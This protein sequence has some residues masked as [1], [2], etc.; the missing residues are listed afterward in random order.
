MPRASER[1]ARSASHWLSPRLHWL[2]G[3]LLLGGIVLR[4]LVSIAYAPALLYIDSFRYL[5][6]LRDL[7]PTQLN[8]V[9]YQLFLLKPALFVTKSL[10]SVVIIQHLLGLALAVAIYVVLLRRGARAWVAALATAPVLLDAYQVQIEHNIMSD[11]LF[12]VLLIAAVLLLIWQGAPRVPAAVFAGLLLAAAVITRSVAIPLIVPAAVYVLLVARRRGEPE[13]R[14]FAQRLGVTAALVGAFAL[15]VFSYATYYH[16]YSGSWGVA[17]SSSKVL[18][19]RT[20]TVADC[21][22]LDLNPA[23]EPLC[24]K[25]PLGERYGV[26]V[27]THGLKGWDPRALELADEYGGLDATTRSF[28]N[29]V[30]AAQPLDVAGAILLDFLKNFSLTKETAPNDVPVERWHFQTEYPRW[31]LDAEAAVRDFGGPPISVNTEI[32]SFLRNYQLSVGYLPGAVLGGTLL[33]SVAGMVGLGRARRSDLRSACL[34]VGGLGA[35]I[36]VTSA[37]FEFSW[38]YQ[39]PALV[40]LPLAGALGWTALTRGSATKEPTASGDDR[41]GRLESGSGNS[42][43]G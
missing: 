10:Q 8:P 31:G 38:R 24:P 3:I 15:G 16:S 4:V 27:Y 22:K 20:A 35:A 29:K 42:S 19:G 21:S 23:E 36:L 6:N 25:E 28:A 17:G 11:L 34:L 1:S 14:R 33:L 30:L 32:A 40:L 39:V 18:Y 9:G 26:D 5:D 2:F 43:G 37:A 7:D 13:P 12:Q 41:E